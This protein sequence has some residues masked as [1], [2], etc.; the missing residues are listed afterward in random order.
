MPA[1]QRLSTGAGT[2]DASVLPVSTSAEMVTA[3]R[4]VPR[5]LGTGQLPELFSVET[6]GM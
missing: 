3:P 2:W 4:G 6:R 5:L 1:V